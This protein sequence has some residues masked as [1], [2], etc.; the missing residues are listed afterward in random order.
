M[1]QR[2]NEQMLSPLRYIRNNKRR[3]SVLVISLCL[4]FAI[5]YVTNFL[6]MSTQETAK[7]IMVEN[8][9]KMQSISLSY[10]TIGLDTEKYDFESE[11]EMDKLKEDEAKA[12]DDAIKKLEKVD[13]IKKAFRSYPFYLNI[14]PPI[15]ALDYET[16]MTD[17]ENIKPIMDHMGASLAEGK[18]PEKKGE[19]IID[20]AS[21]LNN[22][23]AVGDYLRRSAFDQNKDYTIVGIADCDTYFG[24]GVINEQ[25][26]VHITMLTDDSITDLEK[27]LTDIGY[28]FNKE[29]D[30]V[31]D[32][33]TYE[34]FYEKFVKKEIEQSTEYIYI[35]IFI[36]LFISLFVV[37]TTYLR[38]RHNE[39]CLYCSIGYSRKT[40]YLSIMGELI[41]TFITA[42]ILGA[43]I[44]ALMVFGLDALMMRPLGIAC[45]YF[46]PKTLAEILCAFVLL[47][48]LL[49]I[50]VRYALYKIRTIDAMDDDI[51]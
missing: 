6:V 45:R 28:N 12:I 8:L 32:F 25:K 37:Y 33:K 15:A 5:I 27:V 29:Y 44:T 40:I 3:V 19:V 38:D 34:H 2:T 31:M 22:H 24:C 51:Y 43:I 50:P 49:Q 7:K 4:C 48:A 9:H 46:Y 30:G 26:G 18:I 39:W 17:P 10:D 36:L 11:A 14:K 42:I 13:G 1:K 23:L 21:A 20:R 35:G 47:L 41:F 16:Y